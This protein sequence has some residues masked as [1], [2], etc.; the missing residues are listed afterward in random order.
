MSN[1]LTLTKTDRVLQVCLI[2][3]IHICIYMNIVRRY[4]YDMSDRLWSSY[5]ES[6]WKGLSTSEAVRPNRND[7]EFLPPSIVMNTAVIPANTSAPLVFKFESGGVNNAFYV[8][9]HC[10]EIQR[11]GPNESR[12]FTVSVNG[13]LLR[14][15]HSPD[16]LLTK[17]LWFSEP[18]T[19]ELSYVLTL[20]RLENSTLP[21]IMNAFE[22]YD[23]A[24]ISMQETDEDDGIYLY[25]H[26]HD[27]QL[28]FFFFVIMTDISICNFS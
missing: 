2:L 20:D 28:L 8:F 18:V 24:Y 12:A 15:P 27:D 11:L 21:P 14:G 13:E 10:A 17:T 5:S 4:P 26:M 22:I 3:L 9:L 19:G 1:T 6:H 23:L 16:Y 7:F 25:I